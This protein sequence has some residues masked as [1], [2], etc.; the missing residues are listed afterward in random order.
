MYEKIT[1]S[2]AQA[3]FNR[4]KKTARFP[5]LLADL[6]IARP[7]QMDRAITVNVVYLIISKSD[8]LRLEK[9][10]KVSSQIVPNFKNKEV[11]ALIFRNNRVPQDIKR[12]A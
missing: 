3:I 2:Q 10:I 4:P 11:L 9:R 1:R 5:Y 8:Q 6:I 7:T 12:F